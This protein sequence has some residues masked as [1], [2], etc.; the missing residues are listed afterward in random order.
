[1]KIHRNKIKIE[2]N[3]GPSKIKTEAV[4]GIDI[5]KP[6]SEIKPKSEGVT[7]NKDENASELEIKKTKWEPKNWMQTLENIRMMRKVGSRSI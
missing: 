4:D 2:Y 3:E 1:M 7:V 6:K 5:K